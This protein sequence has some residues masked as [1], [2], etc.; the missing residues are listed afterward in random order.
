M[1]RPLPLTLSPT[2]RGGIP[3]T[4][5]F[6]LAFNG[7]AYLKQPPQADFVTGAQRKPV[8]VASVASRS[9]GVI[10]FLALVTLL[11]ASCGAPGTIHG[12]GTLAP[13]ATGTPTT[14]PLP[15]VR[16][17]QDEAPHHNLTEW[18]YY[19]G[20]LS[21][22]DARGETHTYGFE[23]T[24]FQ[25][26]R[27]ALSPYYAAHFA[28]SDITAGQFHY[29]E[30]AGFEPLS[31]IPAPG[32]TGGFNLALGGWAMRGLNGHDQLSASMTDYAIALSL[33]DQ[34]K[35]PILHNGDGIISYGAAGYSYYYSRPL[36]SVSGKLTDHD[37]TI[38]VTG[39]AWMDHQWGDFVSL[40]G[41]GWDWYSIQLGNHTEYML[42]VIR[43]SQ[44]RPLSVFGT[45]VA[46][47]GSAHEIAP[48]AIHSQ[49]TGS[50]KSPVTGGVYPS[51]WRV[52]L[53]GAAP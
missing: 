50:W 33:T 11:L 20:H 32:S 25:T 17:P 1:K 30:R 40:A 12:G 19:T 6:T 28:V 52:T 24:F 13:V 22:V 38:N 3:L 23:L 51:G 8:G 42:Y 39:Q 29:D 31:T 4:L 53:T 35:Q 43:D 41:A 46:A 27:G 44:K 10:A 5:P 2:R 14:I 36:M 47:D 7:Q 21:G 37:A 26:L 48:T 16:F 45:A 15:S 34:L 9:C 18:W 49:A